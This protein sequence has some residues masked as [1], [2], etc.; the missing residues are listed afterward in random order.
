MMALIIEKI[1]Q[2]TSKIS[3]KAKTEIYSKETND[4]LWWQEI[5]RS[6]SGGAYRFLSW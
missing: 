5:F 2:T 6:Q 1:V 4:A 3:E